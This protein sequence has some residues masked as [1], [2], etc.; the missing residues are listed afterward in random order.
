[1]SVKGEIKEGTGFVKEE[2]NET[3]Q[4]SGESAKGP[5]RPRLAKRRSRGG[6]QDAEDHQARHR[7]LRKVIRPGRKAE[8]R[9]C[10]R[11]RRFL[12]WF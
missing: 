4:V 8:G 12:A 6:R 9:P 2:M 1:M 3:Q 5:G 11:G 7:S 10:E